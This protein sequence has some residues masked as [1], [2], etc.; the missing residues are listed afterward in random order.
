MMVDKLKTADAF[1]EMGKLKED[2]GK[3]LNSLNVPPHLKELLARIITLLLRKINVPQDEINNFVEE[4]D[5]RGVNAMLSIENY[6]VQETRRE[7][8]AEAERQKEE[9]RRK[10]EKAEHQRE[11][12]EHQ[13]E[14]AE[15]RLK[16]A[17]KSLLD[18]GT[19]TSEIAIM[20]GI[21]EQDVL[22]MIQETE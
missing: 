6:D 17:I 20:M 2:Y 19:T 9:E 1:I 10:R 7:A 13:R 15:R 8:R 14:K 18:K 4:F 3:Q 22:D 11:K 16:T 12:A 21:S 5:E